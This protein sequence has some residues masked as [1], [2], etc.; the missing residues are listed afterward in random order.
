[1]EHWLQENR[2]RAAS[3][4]RQNQSLI[5]ALI[6]PPPPP[7]PPPQPPVPPRPQTHPV[8][9]T[10]KQAPTAHTQEQPRHRDSP[11]HQRQAKLQALQALVSIKSRATIPQLE[12]AEQT[13][14]TSL[15]ASL[16]S[17]STEHPLSPREAW[18]PQPHGPNHRLN[19]AF[20]EDD[21]SS[22]EWDNLEETPC[23]MWDNLSSCSRTSYQ[24]LHFTDHT[25][26]H[27]EDSLDDRDD[28][29]FSSPHPSTYGE[30]S[31]PHLRRH[32]Y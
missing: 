6:P 17:S 24:Q 19:T 9:S 1:M 31:S 23:Y 5:Q 18:S 15:E 12:G 21:N 30:V 11:P 10:K 22:L 27:G 20:M 32:T 28:L 2:A 13:P 26:N 29:L 8:I 4:L 3:A 7:P 14:N 16:N 25:S